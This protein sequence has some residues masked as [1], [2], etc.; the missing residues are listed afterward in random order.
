MSSYNSKSCTNNKKKD[1]IQ[2]EAITS[3]EYTEA[4]T[5]CK[6]GENLLRSL[7]KILMKE[8]N[9]KNSKWKTQ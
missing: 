5:L 6:I 2:R 4:F 3:I 7:K 1:M 9:K 8:E